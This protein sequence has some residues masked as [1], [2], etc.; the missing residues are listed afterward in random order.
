[1]DAILNDKFGENKIKAFYTDFAQDMESFNKENLDAATLLMS[2][3]DF[4]KFKAQM[5]EAKGGVV[6]Q[7]AG[8]QDSITESA[9]K[10][11]HEA[12]S[13][14]DLKDP[15]LQWRQVVDN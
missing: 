12:L 6:N 10:Y 13:K 3:I 9:K 14:E 2:M 15:A 8:E 11:S 1:M 4:N 7:K 5:I